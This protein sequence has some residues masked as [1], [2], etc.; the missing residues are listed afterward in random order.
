MY[1]QIFICAEVTALSARASNILNILRKRFFAIFARQ[2]I[3]FTNILFY[4]R[5]MNNT[6]RHPKGLYLLFVT[7]LRERFSY[8][9][10][11][12]VHALHGTGP[13]V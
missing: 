11:G 10:R 1:S 5:Q 13:A 4:K 7:E 8:Y 2:N 9:G 12:F 3:F 6:K